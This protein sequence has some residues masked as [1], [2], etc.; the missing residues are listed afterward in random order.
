MMK[1]QQYYLD[2]PTTTYDYYT[3]RCIVVICSYIVVDIVSTSSKN[4]LVDAI[5]AEKAAAR[6]RLPSGSKKKQETGGI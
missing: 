4:V 3:L 1:L 5:S 6:A 2:S